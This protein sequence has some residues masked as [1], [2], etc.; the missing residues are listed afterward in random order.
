MEDWSQ[1]PVFGVPPGVEA[2][3]IR[4]SAYGVV[5]D[6]HG[7]VAV[8]RTGPERFGK[9]SRRSRPLTRNLE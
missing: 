8:V 6:E 1:A 5:A 3:V 2:W 9:K 4:E 7:R